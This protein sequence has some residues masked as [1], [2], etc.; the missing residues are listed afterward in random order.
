MTAEPEDVRHPVR[1]V[2]LRDRRGRAKSQRFA[3]LCL[4]LTAGVFTLAI[5]LAG[6]VAVRIKAGAIQI[7]SLGQ[8]IAHSLQDR[9]GNGLRFSLGG[10][11]IVQH[12]FGPSLSVDRLSVTGPDGQAILTAPRAELSVDTLALLGGKV[13][14]KR[15]EVFNVTLRAVLLKN[16]NLA[17]VAADG[18]RPF[19]EI[20]HSGEDAA[21]GGTATT[22]QQNA[23]K[24]PSDD[25]ETGVSH[26]RAVLMRKA[27]AGLRQF[28]DILTDGR[29][30]IAAVDRLAISDGTLVIQD[31]ETN[32]ETVYRGLDLA[33]DR[34]QGVTSFTL[35]A[36]GPAG[37]WTIAA[38]AKGQI[39]GERSFGL[40]IRDLTIDELRLA[41]GSRSHGFDTDSPLNLHLDL[42]LHAD[43]TLSEASGG[44]ELGAGY[45]RTD[46]PD[47]EPLLIDAVGAEFHWN[48][49]H[50]RVMLDKVRYVEGDTHFVA[51][52][53][54][55]TPEH[56]G[57]PWEVA[58]RLTE[59]GVFAPDRKDQQPIP[60]AEGQL[61]GRLLLDRK[62]F[63]IDRMS[64]RPK[65]GGLALAGEFDW[66][67]GPHVRLGVSMD[68]TAVQVIER[69]W[70]SP[71]A[72]E[73]R[74]W[75][76]NHFEAGLISDGVM[77]IDYD[78]NDLKRMRADV[79]P[80]DKSVSIDFKVAN[81][82]LRY[83]DGVPPLDD[84]VGSAHI[85]G[86]TSSF[87]VSSATSTIDGFKVQLSNGSFTVPNSNVHPVQA[88]MSAHLT[89]S[90]EAITGIL[91]RDALKRFASLPLDPKTLH[92]QI[93]GDLKKALLL[94]SG[95]ATDPAQTALAVNAEVSSF[96]ADRIIGKEGLDNANMT[97]SVADG[98]LRATGQG[99]LF[100]SPATFS[101]TRQGTA[102]PRA[103]IG[104]TLDEAARTKL[105]LSAVPGVVGPI[106][107]HVDT[108]L[109]GDPSKI[110]AQV[111]LDLAKTSIAA[112]Y[113]GLSKPA[114]RPAK[115]T[116]TLASGS[117]RMLIDPIALDIGPLQGKGSI[118]LGPDNS[119]QGAHFSSLK[120]SP[121]DDMKLD[122]A[123]SDD[124]LKLTIR[125][126]TID[127]RPF[128]KA[129]TSIPANEPTPLSRNARAEKKEADSF[130][131][132]EVDL[133]SNLLT[134]A[135]KEVMSGAELKLSKRGAAIRQFALQGRFG[136]SA[137][138]GAMT[139]NGR[140]RVSTQDAGALVSFIDLYKHMEGGNLSANM[141]MNDDALAGSLEIHDFVLR[142]EP[143]I[144][145]LVATSATMSAPGQDTEAVRRI[146]GGE[147]DFKRLKVNFEREG[148]HLELRDATMYGPQIGLSVD[149]WLD[150]THDLVGMKGTFVPAFAVNNLF[151]Q[152]PVFGMFLGGKSNE[153]L[154]AITFN[155]SGPAS[156]PNL[157]I[158]PLSVIAPGFLRNIFGILDAPNAPKP[159]FWT[160]GGDASR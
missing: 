152:I 1:L 3:R 102:A 25:A 84:M 24:L 61:S 52:G 94:G 35:S 73:V 104:L 49:A 88:Y 9:F 113:L 99:R 130:K 13:S 70:P 107:A 148:S 32:E 116:F 108:T 68:P 2:A 139:S 103:V 81:G 77:Q 4:K 17:L 158:N 48:A 120:I 74:H 23:I 51:A 127:A 147:V 64:F 50:R 122:V 39:G 44:F 85:T 75:I 10:T 117:D 105:G 67:Q 14:P 62:T 5:L 8:T 98:A 112:A 126:T 96:Q 37:R 123:K 71:M 43:N 91:S 59:P 18:S 141:Q 100:G 149:G 31:Q 115:V 121:G 76:L 83:L 93:D 40:R 55:K 53:E 114:G 146:D 106:A 29:S 135:N 36:E 159:D 86:R 154:L 54:V 38:M 131:S 110:K 155:I 82:R 153:G 101:I 30:P 12:G 109:G 20:G 129:L 47:Y 78:E 57:E 134:G 157:S 41:A 56:E 28:L 11:S 34:R 6:V 151:S 65:D 143:A 21:P 144:R 125:G 160:R 111:E 133:K 63:M 128:L 145:R 132:F 72:A 60:V 45:L 118:E 119:V 15:L 89:G 90:V 150:Y 46:D 138:S 79:A 42:G 95:E 66:V 92:G 137:V 7:D 80:K 33:F 69:V 22:P 136:R 19:L 140:I 16:G 87:V 142:D 58:M 26:E 27:A 124:S 97:F 156:Q